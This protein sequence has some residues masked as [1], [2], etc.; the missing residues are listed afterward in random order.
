M[1][2]LTEDL[3]S[4]K[5]VSLLDDYALEFK[6]FRI[7]NK[8][9]LTIYKKL[10]CKILGVK[11]IIIYYKKNL[12][13]DYY[14][15]SFYKED[16]LIY[17]DKDTYVNII[18]NIN[19]LESDDIFYSDSKSLEKY[20]DYQ[21]LN[22]ARKVKD[23]NGL[24]LIKDR[25]LAIEENID[26]MHY[27]QNPDRIFKFLNTEPKFI[28][29]FP[30][31]DVDTKLNLENIDNK[32][33]PHYNLIHD[34]KYKLLNILGNHNLNF[35][36]EDINY[37]LLNNKLPFSSYSELRE[38]LKKYYST[39]KD[40][41][42]STFKKDSEDA[43]NYLLGRDRVMVLEEPVGYNV[44]TN[45]PID[46]E[47]EK[48]MKAKYLEKIKEKENSPMVVDTI[49]TNKEL[50]NLEVV[51]NKFYNP[52]IDFKNYLYKDKYHYGFY[53]NGI[54]KGSLNIDKEKSKAI[55]PED[56]SLEI[57]EDTDDFY[58][59]L[60]SSGRETIELDFFYIPKDK[61]VFTEN[62]IIKLWRLGYFLT[63]FG[64]AVY[65]NEN[66]VLESELTVPEWFYSQDKD[67][68]KKLTKIISKIN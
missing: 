31:S 2:A 6:F 20:N 10:F 22:R 59:I 15:Y 29:F 3:E 41:Y 48:N 9:N 57:L 27:S 21:N 65:K 1:E 46:L 26:H 53:S 28:N 61:I 68:Y 39:P 36:P 49:M 16:K 38:H 60:I 54:Y 23:L 14:I 43:H 34:D 24:V 64:K 12:K 58:T 13:E 11:D 19:K 5:A 51:D 4:Y 17:T 25:K 7:P 35:S 42:Y 32:K 52:E 62:M 18:E 63:A 40:V 33:L 47:E 37:Y 67:S 56:M 44:Y 30:H 45:E 8:D 66:R 55:D 50:I